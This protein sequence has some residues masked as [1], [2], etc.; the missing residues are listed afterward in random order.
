MWKL[1][2]CAVHQTE[3]LHLLHSHLQQE[4]LQIRICLKENQSREDCGVHTWWQIIIK[5]IEY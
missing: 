2:D 5:E 4:D 3:P 1:A